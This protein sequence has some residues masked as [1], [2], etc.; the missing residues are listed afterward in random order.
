MNVPRNQ[1]EKHIAPMPERK[2]K[3][4]PNVR[5]QILELFLQLTA[6]RQ[7]S[8]VDFVQS[9]LGVGREGDVADPE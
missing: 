6:E 5:D 8:A 2:G 7:E 1:R 3:E 4:M 9:M